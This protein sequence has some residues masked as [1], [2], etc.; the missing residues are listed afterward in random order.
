M[1]DACIA[2]QTGST[3]RTR[4]RTCSL[5]V[6]LQRRN[7]MLGLGLLGTVLVIVL[8]GWPVVALLLELRLLRLL[9]GLGLLL[10]L[11]RLA[12]GIG[13]RHRLAGILILH[14]GRGR[15]GLRGWRGRR[16]VEPAPAAGLRVL[17]QQQSGS[18]EEID[19]NQAKT[20]HKLPLTGRSPDMHV[21]R[22]S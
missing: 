11:L 13:A 19:R 3:E 18:G 17:R 14:S 22:H 21:L 4:S 2:R 7:E 6:Y 1:H 8:I 10:R 5:Q 15:L 16:I 12:V 20:C 9:L